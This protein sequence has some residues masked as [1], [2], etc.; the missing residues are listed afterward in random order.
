MTTATVGDLKLRDQLSRLNA[1][2]VLS[3]LMTESPDE[4]QIIRLG[5]SA[6]PSFADCRLVGVRT[7]DGTQTMWTSGDDDLPSAEA[8]EALPTDGGAVELP[9]AAWGWAYSLGGLGMPMGHMVVAADREL[10]RDEHFLLRVL[11]QQTGTAVHNSRLHQFERTAAAELASVNAKL[12]QTVQALKQRIDIH[13]RLTRAAVSGKGMESIAEAVHEVTGLPVVIEDRFGNLR[14][15]AGPGQPPKYPKEPPAKREEMLRRLLREGQSLWEAG[16]VIR[17]ASPRPGSVSVIAL[18]D[19]DHIARD[20]D[21]AALEY[22]ATIVSME[23][24]RLRSVADTEIRVRRDLVEDLLSGTSADSAVQ[25]GEAFQHDLTRPHRV[26]VFEGLGRSHDEDHFFTAVRRATRDSSLGSLLVARAGTV[27]LLTERDPDWD[28]VHAAVVR[29]LAGGRCLIGVGGRTSGVGDFPAS[30][31]EALLALNLIKGQSSKQQVVAF[32][33]LGVYRLLATAE[34]PREIERYVQ[35][36]LGPLLDYDERR[37]S[38]LVLT[39]YHYLDCGGRY[40]EAAKALSVH[41]STLKY[42]LQR[43]RDV[44]Q[45]QLGEPDVNFNLQLACRAWRTLQ[46]LRS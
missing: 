36:W 10:D 37:K 19:P 14:A 8:M 21:L 32:D 1:L 18:I 17:A 11:A 4:E 25:R 28:V 13:D 24:A 42:R 20:E 45:L 26:A 30:H 38:E 35:E 27:V 6:A 22:G 23:L 40:D 31:R 15:W 16:R 34:D 29:E 2:L 46:A 43:I 5:A 41:R 9:G 3:M 39:L 12:E 44:S 33:R 7:I